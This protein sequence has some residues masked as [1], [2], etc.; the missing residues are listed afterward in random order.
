MLR[1]WGSFIEFLEIPRVGSF[2]SYRPENND[3]EKNCEYSP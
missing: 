1:R 3:Y 2:A